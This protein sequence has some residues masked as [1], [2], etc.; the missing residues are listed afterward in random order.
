M[1]PV[2]TQNLENAGGSNPGL[3]IEGSL[4]HPQTNQQANPKKTRT[5]PCAI[6]FIMMLSFT[7]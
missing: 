7:I 5:I 3:T 6:L 4:K 2:F 1:G